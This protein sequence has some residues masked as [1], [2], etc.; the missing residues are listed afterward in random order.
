MGTNERHRRGIARFKELCLD[1]CPPEGVATTAASTFWAAVAGLEQRFSGEPDPEHDPGDLFGTEEAQNIAFCPV[2]EAKTVKHRVH[3]DVNVASVEDLV[4]LGAT[5]LRP[6]DASPDGSGIAWTVLV[7]PEGGEFC[8]FVRPPEKPG[9][10]R[11]FEV[12]VD[13]VDAPAIA[14]WWA[15]AF[16]VEVRSEGDW[17]WVEGAPG[18]PSPAVTPYWAMVFGDVPEPKAVKNRLHWDVYGRVEDFLARGA[19]RLWEMP[20]WTV[21][22]DPEGNEFCVFP[23]D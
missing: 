9:G 20:R 13:A 6:A 11:V 7:D 15:E 2:P 21:L 12:A 3:L 19:T 22:A 23:P 5:V 8:A 4:A 14:T 16:G 10:Y 1:T 17:W 18:F